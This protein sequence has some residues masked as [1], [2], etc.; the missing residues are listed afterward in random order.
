MGNIAKIAKTSKQSESLFESQVHLTTK[1]TISFEVQKNYQ[2]A[3][4]IIA[5]LTVDNG[6]ASF[7]NCSLNNFLVSQIK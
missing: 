1:Q 2:I 4:F 3:R 6:T 5:R 7:G